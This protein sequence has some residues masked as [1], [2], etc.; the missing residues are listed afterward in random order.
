M[1]L[2]WAEITFLYLKWYHIQHIIYILVRPNKKYV[3]F[4]WHAPPPMFSF[5]IHVKNCGQPNIYFHTHFF[6]LNFCTII[7]TQMDKKIRVGTKNGR[8]TG[9]RH[10]LFS[11]NRSI[12]FSAVVW[13]GE[14]RAERTILATYMCSTWN[15]ERF[16]SFYIQWRVQDLTLKGCGLCRH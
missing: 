10:F 2:C 6:V 7:L 3:L 11:L 1:T 14:L 8:G 4:L 9:T 13:N 12:S 16:A 15:F 5:V